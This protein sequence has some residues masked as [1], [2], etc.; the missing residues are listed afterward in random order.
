MVA[1]LVPA[2]P[3]VGAYAASSPRA[4][5][6]AGCGGAGASGSSGLARVVID[7]GACLKTP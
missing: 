6:A 2:R 4:G 1:V 3:R 5:L 7:L